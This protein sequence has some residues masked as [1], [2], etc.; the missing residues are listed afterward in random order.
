MRAALAAALAIAAA[1]PGRPLSH[2]LAWRCCSV[3]VSAR[4]AATGR[5][6]QW[7]ARARTAVAPTQG[8]PC[9]PDCGFVMIGV[10]LTGTLFVRWFALAQLAARGRLAIASWRHQATPTRNVLDQRLP[11]LATPGTGGGRVRCQPFRSPLHPC[12]R[13]RRALCAGDWRGGG[14]GGARDRRRGAAPRFDV[15][16]PTC[17][18]R[19]T[20]LTT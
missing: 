19:F 17:L 11:Q 10:S 5:R 14:L 8:E 7:A 3:R 13:T 20:G 1:R 12:G 16:P 15:C 18:R 4:P 9:R 6:L 2:S